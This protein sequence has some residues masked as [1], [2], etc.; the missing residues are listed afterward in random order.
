MK[1]LLIIDRDGT[2]IKEPADYQIDAFEKLEFV[3]GVFTWLGRIAREFD[4]ELIMATNQ[5]GLGTDSF[6]EETFYGPQKLLL[7][8]LEGEGIVFSDI[9]VDRSFDQEQLP[10]RKPGTGMFGKYLSGDYNLAESYVIGDRITDVQLARNLGA[11]AIFFNNEGSESAVLRSTSWEEIYQFLK[12]KRQATVNRKTSETDI[13]VSVDLDGPTDEK[14]DTGIGFLNHMLEQIARH[15]GIGLSVSCQGDLHIDEHHSA[16]DV[17]ITLGLALKQALGNKAGIGR[18]GFALPMD[19]CQAKVLLD[20]G[21]RPYFIWKAKFKRE[22][23]GDMA[24]EL[25]PHFF[26]SIA[27]SLG[28][29]L[30]IRAKGDNE[31]HKAEAIFKAFAR[32]LRQAIRQEGTEL[33]TTKGV[34]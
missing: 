23:I 29:N 32:A 16:E 25:L 9:L 27:D 30:H 26:R 22:K 33:P 4:Y 17:A 8:T 10:T 6:P 20:L 21:G 34:I 15:A 19:D 28:A 12:P 13:I 2:L 5:D 3:P 31:H 18:Y 24:T 1:K 14:I 11:Q 7:K